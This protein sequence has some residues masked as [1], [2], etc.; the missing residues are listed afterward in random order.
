MLQPMSDAV[1][2][3]SPIKQFPQTQFNLLKFKG[4]C[5]HIRHNYTGLVVT[6]GDSRTSGRG[7]KSRHRIL[8]GHFSHCID[9]KIVMFA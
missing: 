3:N 2:H 8:D 6:G 4:R 7:I 5:L 9:V 1:R